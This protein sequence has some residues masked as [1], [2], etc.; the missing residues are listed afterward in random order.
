MAKSLPA[1]GTATGGAVFD[2]FLLILWKLG[3]KGKTNKKE[4]KFIN[5]LHVWAIQV[6]ER[7]TS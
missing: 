3:V 7:T 4:V 1:G 5:R 2:V 6:P